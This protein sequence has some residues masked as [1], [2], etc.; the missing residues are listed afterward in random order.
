M[1]IQPYVEKLN[2]SKEFKLFKE[3]YPDSFLVAGFFV[4]DL[5]M[6]RNIHQIDYFI[7]S[8]KKFA[9]FTL[10]NQVQVQLLGTMTEKV[11]EK[12][13]TNIN[14][15]LEAIH[16]ILEDEMRNRNMSEEIKKIIAVVQN[17]EG[18]KIWN[19]NCVLSGMEI[20]KAHV[21]D[22]SKSVLR[23]EKISMM[24]LMKKLPGSPLQMNA[25]NQKAKPEDLKEEIKRLD[26][27]A[28]EIEKEKQE[29]EGQANKKTK[30]KTL[31]K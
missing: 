14:V 8:Q 9:A 16:G 12:L 1:N 7:P 31:A 23:M 24:D 4:L 21:E 20:L 10:D 6:N 18:R 13:D 3:K 26:D 5:E 19:L 15:D 17:V 30:K 11:P 28:K 25:P 27:L 29:L 22:S 2:A